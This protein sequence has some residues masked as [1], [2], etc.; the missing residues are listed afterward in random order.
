MSYTL[1]AIIGTTDSLSNKVNG[2][3]PVSL[4]QNM[5]MMLFNS[6]LLSAYNFAQ[7]PLTDDGKA[8]D[9][10]DNI[11][12][13]CIFMSQGCSI[14]YVEAEYFGGTGL[15]AYAHFQNGSLR[16]GPLRDST[17]INEALRI[18]GVEATSQIDEFTL[19][20]LDQKRE[21]NSW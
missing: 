14:V 1:Q 15:Q 16:R 10:P 3:V 4:K 5:E 17:A 8:V 2:V 13:F 18:L 9:L 21:T 20:G 12:E 6:D 7:L 19:V 11:N